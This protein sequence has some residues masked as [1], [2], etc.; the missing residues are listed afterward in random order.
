MKRGAV[1]GIVAGAA[2]VAIVAGGAWWLFGRAPSAEDAARTYLDAL[3]DGDYA[4]IDGMQGHPLGEA[5]EKTL[6]AA[7]TGA[8]GYIGDPRIEELST[9]HDGVTSVRADVELAGERRDLFFVMERASGQWVLI[10]DFLAT[11]RIETSMGDDLG[12]DAAWAGD[13]LVPAHTDVPVLPAEYA[14][15]AAPR[16]IL[17]GSAT[18]AVSNDEPSV[19]PLDTTLSPE[20]TAAAQEQ[21]DA[22]MDEC[23][24][25]ATAVPDGCG[26]RVPWAVDLSTLD[27]IAF[28]IEERPVVVLSGDARSFDASG[29]VIVATATGTA[30]DGGP[31]AFT[32]RADDWALRGSIRFDGDEMILLVG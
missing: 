11:L 18:A 21:L 3:A 20:A 9:D 29:G 25:P 30:R 24:E 17:S 7:F 4:T 31:A 19:V 26:L 28:R 22:Y 2:A 5:E 15:E 12:G 14:I 13:A 23:T 8:E 1:V 10:C 16:G 32:Y 27:A 6:E